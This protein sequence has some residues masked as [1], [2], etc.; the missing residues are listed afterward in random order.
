VLAGGGNSQPGAVD[1]EGSEQAA[2]EGSGSRERLLA[3]DDGVEFVPLGDA[4]PEHGVGRA[5]SIAA[6]EADA[7]LRRAA[8]VGSAREGGIASGEE[9]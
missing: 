3:G 7:A 6:S 8:E 4:A 1:R 2:P 5:V 9:P